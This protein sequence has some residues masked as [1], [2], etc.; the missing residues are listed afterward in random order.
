ML[1]IMGIVKDQVSYHQL[2]T[3]ALWIKVLIY[4][5]VIIMQIAYPLKLKIVQM[6]QQIYK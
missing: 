4:L 5:M 6:E 2:T 3:T 1:V